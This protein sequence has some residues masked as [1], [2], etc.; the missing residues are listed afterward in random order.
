VRIGV[1]ID[2]VIR[3]FLGSFCSQYEKVTGK[4][5]KVAE[6]YFVRD[7]IDEPEGFADK[8][9]QEL[10]PDQIYLGAGVIGN[11]DILDRLRK[12][13]HEVILITHQPTD[14]IKILTLHWVIDHEVPHDAL[15]FTDKK[16]LIKVDV[17]LDDSTEKLLEMESAGVVAVAYDAPYNWDWTGLKVKSLEEFEALVKQLYI[18]RTIELEH[19]YEYGKKK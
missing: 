1:D 14:Y 11:L 6:S 16:S 2:G 10:Y 12:S 17:H 5:A 3:D 15:A 7:W 8:F 19:Q 13:G 18:E 4:P 9:Y